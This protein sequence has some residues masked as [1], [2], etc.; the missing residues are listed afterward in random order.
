MEKG[1]EA[2]TLDAVAREAVI[3]KGGLLYHFP[4]KNLLIQGMI[5]NMI[6]AVDATLAE[7]LEKSGGDFLT[8]YIRASFRTK[9]ASEKLSYALFAAIANDPSLIEPV[10]E[11]FFRMQRMISA[12]AATE[13]VATLIRLAL[14]GLWFSDLMQFAPPSAALRQKIQ[15][16]LLTIASNET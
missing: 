10:R 13:E 11:R 14:D 9:A 1:T 3:S 16:A 15:I 6:S 8:A 12:T 7:E 4:S 5:E 2:F